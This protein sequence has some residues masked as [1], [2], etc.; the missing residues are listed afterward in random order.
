MVFWETQG[1]GSNDNSRQYQSLALKVGSNPTKL[2][3]HLSVIGSTSGFEPYSLG[4]NPRGV[5][6][7]SKKDGGLKWINV[8]S[9]KN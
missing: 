1:N 4:P 7:L 9:H 8:K 3:I 2:S 6:K 5:L